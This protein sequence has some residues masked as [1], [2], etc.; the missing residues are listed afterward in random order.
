MDKRKG[1]KRKTRSDRS[2]KGR[3]SV[4]CHAVEYSTEYTK[5]KNPTTLNFRLIQLYSSV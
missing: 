5:L 2:K 1:R 3:F 4:N